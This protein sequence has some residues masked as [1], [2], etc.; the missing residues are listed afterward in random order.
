[1]E[2]EKREKY[3]TGQAIGL[4]LPLFFFQKGRRS[5]ARS[6]SG[7]PA[8]APLLYRLLRHRRQIL[9]A[10][11]SASRGVARV[12]PLVRRNDAMGCASVE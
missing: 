10:A 8:A 12:F 1:M 4:D 6:A 3:D 5:V 7:K 9:L 11:G 2:G